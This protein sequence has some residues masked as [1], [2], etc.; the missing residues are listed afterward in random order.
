MHRMRDTRTHLFAIYNS[1]YQST[2][3]IFYSTRWPF[4]KAQ[5][6]VIFFAH[7]PGVK[8]CHWAEPMTITL[9]VPSQALMVSKKLMGTVPMQVVHCA[10]ETMISMFWYLF[11]S[12]KAVV[13]FHDWISLNSIPVQSKSEEWKL[14]WHELFWIGSKNYI[15]TLRIKR[16]NLVHLHK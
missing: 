3:I 13:F 12:M 5:L 4:C 10:Q 11:P 16:R 9:K 8:L 14:C 15:S 7:P 2:K 1:V 6:V